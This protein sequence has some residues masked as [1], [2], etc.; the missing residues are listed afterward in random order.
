MHAQPPD[1]QL[2]IV[3]TTA[4]A[5]EAIEAQL[6]EA[7]ALGSAIER[8]RGARL[9]HLQAYFAPE[10]RVPM[11]DVRAMIARLHEHGVPVGPGELQLKSLA[12][13]EWSETWKRHFTSFRVTD[14]LV[15]SPTW[16]KLESEGGGDVIRLDP[17]MA[18]GL[19]DHPTTRG[20]LELMERM[21]P[22]RPDRPLQFR[23]ADVGTGTGILA[24]RAVQLGLGPVEAFDTDPEAVRVARESAELNGVAGAIEVSEGTLPARGA[25][26]Y[27]R[28][29]ANIL[30]GPLTK[31]LPRITAAL[32]PGGE[33]LLAGILIEQEERMREAVT[34]LGLVTRDRI[35]EPAQRGARRWPVLLLRKEDAAGA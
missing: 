13:E 34:S 9:V 23:T 8:K 14:R 3:R 35:C 6:E 32:L 20:C 19:G 18:F 31:L 29:L 24:I 1:L 27:E 15:V 7:G 12:Q 25:G 5:A 4:I 17:G 33:I 2:L 22:A 11:D 16:E 26:P 10:T 30:L 28:V 21:L